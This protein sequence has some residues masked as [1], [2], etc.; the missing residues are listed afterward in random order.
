MLKLDVGKQRSI[1]KKAL[2][3]TWTMLFG[4]IPAGNTV[5]RTCETDTCI[6][7]THLTLVKSQ[8]KPY[9]KISKGDNSQYS[10]QKLM[11]LVEIN[12]ETGCWEWQ[13]NKHKGYGRIGKNGKEMVAHRVMYMECFGDISS[14]E[15]VHRQCSEKYCMNPLHMYTTA[16]SRS[17]D[18]A[19]D[20]LVFELNPEYK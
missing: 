7:P 6:N 11:S 2:K 5:G 14:K 17:S 8:K 13:G 20:D 19:A 18:I 3:S 15:F 12:Q 10:F 1:L 16:S 4:K 9:R